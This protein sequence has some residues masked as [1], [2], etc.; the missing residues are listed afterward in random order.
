[1]QRPSVALAVYRRK[2]EQGEDNDGREL[3]GEVQKYSVDTIAP[4]NH[5]ERRWPE[6]IHLR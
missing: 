1:M 4:E 3:H 2:R 5:E 6:D